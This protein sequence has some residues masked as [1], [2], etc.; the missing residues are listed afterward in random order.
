MF[1]SQGLRLGVTTNLDTKLV[2]DIVN[3]YDIWVDHVLSI[4]HVNVYSIVFHD[5]CLTAHKIIIDN[6]EL[7]GLIYAFAASFMWAG[8]VVFSS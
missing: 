3:V 6:S 8:I 5:S 1:D 4:K 2:C 7:P